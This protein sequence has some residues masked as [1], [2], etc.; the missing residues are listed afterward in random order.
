M[1]KREDVASILSKLD[2]HDIEETL[3]QPY[4]TA[5]PG[6]PPRS[7]LGIFKALTVKQLRTIPSDR[8]LYRRLWNDEALREICDIEEHEKPYHPSQLTRFRNRV[9][10]ERLKEVMT[11]LLEELV[12]GDVIKGE[13][14]ALDATFIKAW[15]RRDPADDSRG[16]SDPDARVGRDG[17]TYDLGYKAH[18]AVDVASDIPIAAVEASANENEKRHAEGILGEASLV[19]EGFKSVVGDSQYSSKRVRDSIHEHGAL[20]VIPYMSNQRGGVEVLRVDRFFR[21]SGPVEE[22]RIYGLG[23]ASV[24]RV[25]SRLGLVGL[26]SLKLRGLRNVAFH[27]TL[28]IIAMLLVAVAA[29]RLGRPWKAR[30]VLSFWW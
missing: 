12:E 20:P 16:L 8:E 17:K 29:L 9:G 19:V 21:V 23:R 26:G 6:R 25:N 11:G 27:V 30:S 1:E 15:S 3:S 28:C 22:R 13:T 10:P 5:G 2:L 14:I 4:H 24:E 18:V 7:P